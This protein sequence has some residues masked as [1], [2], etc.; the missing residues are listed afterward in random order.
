[1]STGKSAIALLANLK[2]LESNLDARVVTVVD[3]SSVEAVVPQ[4]DLKVVTYPPVHDAS[5][6]A[7][8]PAQLK[9]LAAALKREIARLD[10]AINLAE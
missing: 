5:G 6:E 3:R 10:A 1:M 9:D 2:E 8:L 7:I 4:P